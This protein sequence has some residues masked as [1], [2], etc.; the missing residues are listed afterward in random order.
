LKGLMMAMM[1]FMLAGPPVFHW[2]WGNPALSYPVLP[3]RRAATMNYGQ[4]QLS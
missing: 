2:G 4:T 1:S 3:F